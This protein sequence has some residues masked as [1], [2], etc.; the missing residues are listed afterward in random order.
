MKKIGVLVVA[1]VLAL[2]CLIGCKTEEKNL[3][4]SI[5]NM[6][7]TDLVIFSDRLLFSYLLFFIV[8]LM[9]G[10]HIK[11]GACASISR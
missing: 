8:I 3:H 7:S 1:N 11:E 2:P 9:T 10:V 5:A 6:K 4:H